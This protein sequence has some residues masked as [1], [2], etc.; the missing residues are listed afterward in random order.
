MNRDLNEKE[1][2]ALE[3]LIDAANVQAVLVGVSDICDGKAQHIQDNWQDY[4]L[5]KVW[6]TACGAI[7]MFSCSKEIKHPIISR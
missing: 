6:A 2:D 7:A 4:D 1:M 3:A 5:A